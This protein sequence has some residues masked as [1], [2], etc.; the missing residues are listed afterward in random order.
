MNRMDPT[1]GASKPRGES[2]ADAVKPLQPRILPK[3]FS[4]LGV[5]EM[6]KR[7][8]EKEDVDLDLR[9]PESSAWLSNILKQVQ[10]KDSE[11]RAFALLR[12]R[13][14]L[15]RM[16]VTKGPEVSVGLAA[17][18]L[19]QGMLDE[20]HRI[21]KAA[22]AEGDFY[23]FPKTSSQNKMRY[24]EHFVVSKVD[25]CFR[26]LHVLILDARTAR[27]VLK[28]IPDL[29]SILEGA[30]F[31]SLSAVSLVK[32]STLVP[33][34]A[35]LN[36]LRDDVRAF[37]ISALN[38]LA[39]HSCRSKEQLIR[40]KVLLHQILQD[41]MAGTE[42]SSR[43]VDCTL[44]CFSNLVSACDLSEYLD[45]IIKLV[46]RT[47]AETQ[48][49]VLINI[50][51]HL[52]GSIMRKGQ[53]MAVI[54]KLTGVVWRFIAPEIAKSSP[55][56]KGTSRAAKQGKADSAIPLRRKCPS[57]EKSTKGAESV[58]GKRESARLW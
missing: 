39:S 34:S 19:E 29:I 18:V 28:G 37:S 17:Y 9:K 3:S 31:N 53:A 26:L 38:S 2:R 55:G 49:A 7:L 1:G 8:T 13:A 23:I 5:E 25:I 11:A 52:L 15:S 48:S 20:V 35:Y 22:Q 33:E 47:L 51:V 57:S 40:R 6:K 30:Y 58:E 44:H 27:F 32:D 46:L 24:A 45:D 4:K 41:C 36:L 12:F 56:R 16:V 21:L 50:A 54:D 10:S 14:V 43:M 42:F